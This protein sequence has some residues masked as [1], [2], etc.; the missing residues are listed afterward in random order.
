MQLNIK[1]FFKLKIPNAGI[2]GMLSGRTGKTT[3]KG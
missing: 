1:I 2:K 3:F